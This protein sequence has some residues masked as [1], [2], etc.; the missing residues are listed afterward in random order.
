[1]SGK[2]F[3]PVKNKDFNPWQINFV[4]IVNINIGTWS[5]SADA[6]L[7][8]KKLTDTAGI[9][10]LR[11][12]AA[13]A[14]KSS[15]IYTKVDEEELKEARQ[16]YESGKMDASDTS[17]RLFIGRYITKNPHV[18]GPQKVAMGLKLPDEI[19]TPEVG[20]HGFHPGND[21]SGKVRKMDHLV[22]ENV[23]TLY[24]EKSRAK[25]EG[26]KDIQVFLVITEASVTTAPDISAFDYDGITKRGIYT[27][28]FTQAQIGKRAWYYARY[29]YGGKN[30]S[31][32]PNGDIW[33]SLI[34]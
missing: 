23:I 34:V 3:I 1:M 7:E 2:N 27:R 5:L 12:D 28:L 21:L 14:V 15:G 11:Y 17:L 6:I 16:D 20:V 13:W 18:T 30:A 26:V 19:K 22:H 4:I 10:K 32:G 9:K 31:Y 29:M 8:W 25:P 24:G 33:S